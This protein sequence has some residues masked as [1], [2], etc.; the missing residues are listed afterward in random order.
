MGEDIS[1]LIKRLRSTGRWWADAPLGR[2]A[3]DALE[4]LARQQ[5]EEKAMT[6]LYPRR[7]VND[8]F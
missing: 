8:G 6:C 3:A 2:E 7:K 1:S 4:R 5:V